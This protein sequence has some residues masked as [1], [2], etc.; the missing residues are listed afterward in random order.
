MTLSYEA[1][2]DYYVLLGVEDNVAAE[3]VKRAYRRKA[4]LVHPDGHRSPE[5]AT[6]ATQILNRAYEV[7]SDARLRREYD[8]ARAAHFVRM[9][10]TEIQRRVASELAKRGGK[11]RPGRRRGRTQSSQE[12]STRKRNTA[13]VRHRENAAV[14]MASIAPAGLFTRVVQN[15][16]GDLMRDGRQLEA[17]LFGVGAA[18]LDAWLGVPVAIPTNPATRSS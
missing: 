16:V 17:M 4:K 15:K 9:N 7:L 3:D 14:N 12:G 8:E 18:M 6:E 5:L 10:E 1:K 13:R 2:N 11:A